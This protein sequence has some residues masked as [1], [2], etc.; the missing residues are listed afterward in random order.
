MSKRV[1]LTGKSF[2]RLLYQIKNKGY[3]ELVVAFA[4][5]PN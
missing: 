5:M 3:E 2:G 1:D 4:K